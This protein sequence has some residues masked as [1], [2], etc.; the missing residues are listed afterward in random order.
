MNVLEDYQLRKIILNFIWDFR[1]ET[2]QVKVSQKQHLEGVHT[3]T[4]NMYF[5]AI[6][7]SFSRKI[8]IK[9]LFTNTANLTIK[10]M[11]NYFSDNVGRAF[12]GGLQLHFGQ[13]DFKSQQS[14][15]QSV[16]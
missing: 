3:K 13:W 7:T 14:A 2:F 15:F 11:G 10:A 5:P 4:H 1:E 9:D 8:G 12:R 16:P 6:P